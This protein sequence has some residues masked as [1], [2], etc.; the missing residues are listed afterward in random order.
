M[1]AQLT[2]QLQRCGWV[3][4]HGVS[5]SL[6]LLLLSLPIYPAVEEI[7]GVDKCSITLSDLLHQE[8][9]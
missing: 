2:Q 9:L 8:K 3:L 6:A 5:L 4:C 7:F 1:D